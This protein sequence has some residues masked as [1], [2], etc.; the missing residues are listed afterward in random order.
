ML[1][2]ILFSVAKSAQEK[3]ISIPTPEEKKFSVCEICG[4]RNF[5]LPIKSIEW[6]CRECS[7]PRSERFVAQSK[8]ATG[9]EDTTLDGLP[10]PEPVKVDPAQSWGPYVLRSKIPICKCGSDY[11]E[12]S[13]TVVCVKKFCC[14]CKIELIG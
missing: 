4:S 13:G 10:E 9:S 5:Y 11:F 7:P 1:Q 2:K 8:Q 6:V 12:E 3:N 14:V